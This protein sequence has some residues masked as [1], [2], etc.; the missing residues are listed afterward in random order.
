MVIV[1]SGGAII[2]VGAGEA[3]V[4]LLDRQEQFVFSAKTLARHMW[5]EAIRFSEVSLTNQRL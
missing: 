1:H 3:T 4:L 2:E 5:C